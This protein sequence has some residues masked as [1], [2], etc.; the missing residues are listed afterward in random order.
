MKSYIGSSSGD[1]LS[2]F[3]LVS[4]GLEAQLNS[5]HATLSNERVKIPTFGDKKLLSGL[6]RNI[7][8]HALRCIDDEYRR[9]KD[10]ENPKKGPL[11]PCTNRF[12]DM[13]GLPCARRLRWLIERS[14]AV[15]LTEIHPFW[16]IDDAPLPFK[17]VS[18]FP[19]SCAEFYW[20]CL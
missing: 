14:E 18:S 19:V 15:Q 12:T 7:T 5:I 16:R 3:E 9:L 6:Y 8:R 2:V 13:M 4:K 17:L 11:Q 1:I 10:A 20:G